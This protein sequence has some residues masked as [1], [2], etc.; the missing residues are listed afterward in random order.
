MI[1]PNFK[2]IFVINGPILPKKHQNNRGH[3]LGMPTIVYCVS[4]E[5][6]GVW[7]GLNLVS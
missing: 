7:R 4:F 5:A 1:N 6:P 3:A 2:A